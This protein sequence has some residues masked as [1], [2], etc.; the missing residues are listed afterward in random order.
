MDAF[1]NVKLYDWVG[2]FKS[3]SMAIDAIGQ[4][5]INRNELLKEKAKLVFGET[6]PIYT[7]KEIDPF[8]FIYSLA[9]KKHHKS[10]K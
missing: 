9:Q 4:D 8:S 1:K 10:K 6:H 7:N 5:K 2:Y 3:I